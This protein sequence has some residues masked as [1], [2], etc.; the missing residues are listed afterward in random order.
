MTETQVAFCV[1]IVLT[2]LFLRFV[3]PSHSRSKKDPCVMLHPM[4]A[5]VM[6]Q[7]KVCRG[8]GRRGLAVDPRNFT[9]HEDKKLKPEDFPI[10][11]ECDGRGS[12]FLLSVKLEPII[13]AYMAGAPSL[14][15]PVF[16]DQH[17]GASMQTEDFP[18]RPLVPEPAPTETSSTPP[19][20]TSTSSTNAVGNEQQNPKS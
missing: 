10:C 13:H 1:G 3:A 14:S 7:C 5:N 15:T 11:E 19:S 17:F 20:P 16:P 2:I 8:R 18:S 12:V 4:E 9:H 6:I